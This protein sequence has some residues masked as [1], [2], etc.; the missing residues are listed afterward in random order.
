[1]RTIGFVV[2]PIAGM[3]GRVGLKGTDGNVEEARERGAEQRAPERGAAALK[4]LA[5]QDDSVSVLTWGAEMGAEEAARVGVE[6]EVLGEPAGEVTSR[7]DTI[8]AVEAFLDRDVDLILFVG[9]DGTAVDVY[10]TIAETDGETP[11]LGA[12]AGVKVYSSVFAVSP[13]AAGKIAASFDRTETREVNDIDEDAYREGEV[14]A[15]LRGL[16]TVP[17]AEQLQSSK[18]ILGGDVQG[19]ATGIAEEADPETTYVLGPGGTLDVVKS[20]F[21]IDG[22]P[23]GVDVIRDGELLVADAS[24]DQIL[25]ALGAKNEI[26]VSPIG[27]QGFIFGRG[28]DQ[29]SP[30]VIRQADVT[31]VASGEKM[32][33]TDVLRV[34]TGDADLDESLRGW[35]RVRVGRVEERMVKVV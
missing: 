25:D 21:G 23:L 15:E 31:V 28:N 26:V 29:I 24:E 17:V 5:E 1:M 2:N 6:V 32:R 19:L 14:R 8:A 30:A 3:G 18:Q 12:P 11:M 27:G 34:D 35:I 13:E 4:A 20:A 7:S 9:G 16:A 22:T 33:S 10:E